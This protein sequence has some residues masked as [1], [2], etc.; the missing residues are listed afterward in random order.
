MTRQEAVV[1][2]AF[3]GRALTDTMVYG[4]IRGYFSKK[5]GRDIDYNE[6]AWLV[7]DG[8]DKRIAKPDFDA[9]PVDLRTRVIGLLNPFDLAG[10]LKLSN[11]VKDDQG[12]VG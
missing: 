9:L 5:L 3:T 2:S 4:D 8:E 12:T 11:E 1:I 6:L 10:W 7:L